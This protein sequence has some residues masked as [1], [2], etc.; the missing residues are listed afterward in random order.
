MNAKNRAGGTA[1]AVRPAFATLL[2][3]LGT[4][5]VLH[6]AGLALFT[7][8]FLLQRVELAPRAACAPDAPA[9]VPAAPR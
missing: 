3:L 1:R 4:L 6:A 2:A 8:G 5:L 7:S 9:D